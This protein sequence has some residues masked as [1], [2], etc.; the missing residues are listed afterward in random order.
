MR[1]VSNEQSVAVLSPHHATHV[2]VRVD[3]NG[4]ASFADL[5]NFHGVDWVKGVEFGDSVDAPGF[6]ASVTLRRSEFGKS[7]ATLVQ[8]AE[9]NQQPL[10]NYVPAIT[11]NRVII[12]ETATLPNEAIP[13]ASDWQNVFEGK[14]DDV[15]WGGNNADIRLS[16][17]DKAGDLIDTFI[18][19]QRIYGSAFPGTA[20]ETVIQEILDDNGFAAIILST[21]VSPGFNI[22]PY[23]Q[24][25][26]PVMEAIRK[27]SQQI[28]WECKFRWNGSAWVLTLYEPGRAVVVPVFTWQPDDR[29]AVNQ[30]KVSRANVRNKVRIV[31]TD[32]VSG[33]RT[34]LTVQ[35]LASQA[36]YSLRF[37]E[38]AED[39]SS[40]IDTVAEA[41]QMGNAALSDLKEPFADKGAEL[42]YFFA[43]ETGD[44]YRF[45][46]DGELYDT[47]QDLAIVNFRHR[48]EGETFRTSIQVR[49][50]PAG[51]FQRWLRLEARSGVAPTGDFDA[52]VT[53]DPTV[54]AGMGTLTIEYD[55]PQEPDWLTT[56]VYI[57]AV[58]IP[59]TVYPTKPSTLLL[60]ASGRQTR[61]T[62][63]GLVPGT[64][65]F[66]RIIVIDIKGNFT[67]TSDFISEATQRVGPYHENRDAQLDQLIRNPDF[68]IF[69]FPA[70]ANPPDNWSPSGPQP[71]G[72]GGDNVYFDQVNQLTGDKAALFTMTALFNPNR[73]ELLS[74]YHP[75]RGSELVGYHMLT[76]HAFDSG[77]GAFGSTR[78]IVEWYDSAKVFISSVLKAVGWGGAAGPAGTYLLINGATVQAPA[79]ARYFRVRLD[80]VRTGGVAQT[81][82]FDRA[83]V[84]RGLANGIHTGFGGAATPVVAADTW[85]D[86]N[87]PGIVSG[88]VGTSYAAPSVV[89]NFPGIYQLIARGDIRRTASSALTFLGRV[90]IMVDTGGGFVQNGTGVLLSSD[91]IG[92]PAAV[93]QS[94]PECVSSF[95][96]L[97]LG[98]L[99][100]IQVSVDSVAG[101]AITSGGGF[102]RL[103][104]KQVVR[105]D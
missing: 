28:G 24:Q 1:V 62:I 51:G 37:M 71:W 105:N 55:E 80:A 78:M 102:S 19:V 30:L 70:T 2:R 32:A 77:T 25:K 38:I 93:Q 47:D 54:L 8:Q 87:I 11:V 85:Y 27:L 72:A 74:D 104:V 86:S 56:E 64:T 99:V 73:P 96:D 26:E 4:A 49:G 95:V 35:D 67:G 9:P 65:Y 89:I 36:K 100:K 5:T 66:G 60:A 34:S 29:I 76:K 101:V 7:L 12:I 98:S 88:S 33:I 84:A 20:V 52:P 13:A 83:G 97:P 16:C 22:I 21:P 17:R 91:T 6:T 63:D 41:T 69:T 68:N 18:E 81:V 39:A 61:F 23:V 59:A 44:L 79:T 103:L 75:I 82:W 57:D 53:P 50:K 3:I 58:A 92:P 94:F 43:C 48:I 14:I 42:P 31:Y 45:I 40:Q 90:Q 46:A 15:D 10:G